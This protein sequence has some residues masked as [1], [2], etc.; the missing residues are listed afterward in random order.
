MSENS[1]SKLIYHIEDN[2]ST[3]D[4]DSTDITSPNNSPSEAELYER[5]ATNLL[6][7]ELN[8]IIEKVFEV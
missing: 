6:N 4:N 5:I 2:D 3:Q 8:R 1:N 7:Y